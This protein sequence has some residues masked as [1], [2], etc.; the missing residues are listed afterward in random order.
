MRKR[1]GRS[2]ICRPL[3]DIMSLI[4]VALN[5]AK[6]WRVRLN[7]RRCPIRY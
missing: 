7:D 2:I 3:L 4:G 1:L 5:W 6:E